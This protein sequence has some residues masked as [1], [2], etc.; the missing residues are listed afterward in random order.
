MALQTQLDR[1]TVLDIELSDIVSKTGTNLTLMGGDGSA[2]EDFGWNDVGNPAAIVSAGLTAV[3]GAFSAYTAVNLSLVKKAAVASRAE[4]LANRNA[5]KAAFKITDDSA[6]VAAIAEVAPYVGTA[7]R[8][9]NIKDILQEAK[10]L[11]GDMGGQLVRAGWAGDAAIA[12]WSKVNATAFTVTAGL[13]AL[14]AGLGGVSFLVSKLDQRQSFVL[15]D[16][17]DFFTSLDLPEIGAESQVISAGSLQLTTERVDMLSLAL[18]EMADRQEQTSASV[19]NFAATLDEAVTT[20]ESAFGAIVQPI[21]EIQVQVDGIEAAIARIADLPDVIAPMTNI[22]GTFASPFTALFDFLE[23]PFFPIPKISRNDISKVVDFI[24]TITSLPKWVQKLLDPILDPIFKPLTNIVNSMADKI[25]PFN[26]F[27][28]PMDAFEALLDKLVALIEGI[29]GELEAIAEAL[30]GI[31]DGP[32]LIEEITKAE[33]GVGKTT[34]FGGAQDEI[35]QGAIKAVLFESL[36][37]GSEDV[38]AP[39]FNGAFL[40]GGGGVDT[41]TGTAESDF[42]IGGGGDDSLTGRAAD[43]VLLGGRGHDTIVGGAGDDVAAGGNGD[44]DV[45]GRDGSDLL[46]GGAGD[47]TLAGQAG[48]DDLSG[49]LGDDDLS[50][51]LGDDQIFGDNGDDQ[52]VGEGGRDAIDGGRGADTVDGG[53]GDDVIA[54]DSGDD[55]LQGGNGNDTLDG[56][57]GNDTLAGGNGA[58]ILLGG[59]GDDTLDGGAGRDDL[60]GG[61]ANDTLLGGDGNDRLDGGTGSDD[62]SGDAGRDDLSGGGGEDTLD[63]GDD[64]D[65][66]DGGIGSDDL[67]GGAGRDWLMGGHGADTMRGGADADTFEFFKWGNG[68]DEILDFVAGEDRIRIE[69]RGYDKVA[70]EVQDDVTIITFAKDEIRLVNLTG[71]LS[72]TDFI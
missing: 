45:E 44:D 51:G 14:T 36:S 56:G 24:K 8:R 13:G 19:R 63:G 31:I 43:D 66:L 69:D 62:L 67:S 37:E 17:G 12:S 38:T 71:T 46:T 30:L 58:D 10:F 18:A 54:G 5:L 72:E 40:S 2:S 64:N 49:G 42:L 20:T 68:S 39:A 22:L 34:H 59:F 65:R 41:L 4:I 16:V 53:N 61:G 26:D 55:N 57:N 60:S 28:G 50:G 32:T 3:S 23:D 11:I 21:S 1:L 25:N 15:E 6:R 70:I 33:E 27:A 9:S 35:V 48:D 7:M 47:D 52:I 29:A